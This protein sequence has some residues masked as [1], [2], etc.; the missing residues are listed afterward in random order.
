MEMAEAQIE[1]LLSFRCLQ[2]EV[3][4]ITGRDETFGSACMAIP[5]IIMNATG[6]KLR[7][8]A[9]PM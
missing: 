7:M 6:C 8:Y 2:R 5:I 1:P 9:S 4:Q 3:L